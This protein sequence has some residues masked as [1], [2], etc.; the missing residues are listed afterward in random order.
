MAARPISTGYIS[1]GLVN[2][3]VKLYTTGESS[4]SISFNMLHRK[5]KSRLKQQ[6]VCPTDGE[7]VPRDDMVKGYEFAKDQYVVFN[8]EELK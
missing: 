8:A 4:A 2:I 7:I 3:P 1:F 5:C 6:Y